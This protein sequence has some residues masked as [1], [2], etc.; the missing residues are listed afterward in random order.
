MTPEDPQRPLRILMHCVYFPPEVLEWEKGN[1][2]KSFIFVD[3]GVTPYNNPAFLIY[4][5]ATVGEYALGWP[6][7]ED[8]MMLVSVGMIQPLASTRA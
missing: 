6:T 7:G 3:G 2:E 1:P 5:M 8:K 4:R